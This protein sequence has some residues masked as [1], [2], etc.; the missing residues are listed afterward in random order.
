MIGVASLPKV[1]IFRGTTPDDHCIDF[2]W[3]NT[4]IQQSLTMWFER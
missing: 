1:A 2:H 3:Q 4:T